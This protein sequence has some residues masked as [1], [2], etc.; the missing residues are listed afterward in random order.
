MLDQIITIFS[1]G[2]FLSSL[3]N[4]LDVMASIFNRYM[5]GANNLRVVSII[6][7]LLAFV[8]F[9]FLIIIL[10]VKS[11]ISFLKSDQSNADRKGASIFGDDENSPER[12]KEI[13]LEKE[14]E[15]ELE[16]ELEQAQT[17]KMFNEKKEQAEQQRNMLDEQQKG[18][19]EEKVYKES[20]DR[21]EQETLNKEREKEKAKS[22]T[23]DLDWKKGKISEAETNKIQ[24]DLN[25]MQ[26]QQSRKS[27]EEL[28]GLIIDMSGRGVDDL[29]IA[30]T[31]MF[32]NQGQ[33]TEDDIMQVI[34]AVKDFIALCIN[35]KF[36]NLQSETPIPKEDVALFHLAKGDPSV[37]LA[38]MEVLMD[39]GIDKSSQMT[40]GSKRDAI[41]REI[42]NH[43]C[44]FGSLASLSDV[45]LATGA[46][47]LSIELSP[48]NVNAWSRVADMYA[49]AESNNKAIWAYQNV[50][51]LADEE[52]YARQ[53]ANA[54]KALSQFYY[55]QGNSLQAAKLYNSSKQYY[56]SI[57]IN[58]RLDKKEV[59]IIEIIESR[60]SE[61]METTIAK[62]LQNRDMKQYSYG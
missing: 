59:E 45:H 31:I 55:S 24:V 61:D 19:K 28:L 5:S 30:Q 42:S 21:E 51:S 3:S 9:L 39:N 34:E 41:F 25:S 15:R 11:I 56:D 27:L 44:T 58:R 2:D 50:L 1:S 43:A 52:I 35:G 49:L 13:E 54:N 17:E 37:A 16:R 40:L 10:Y 6:L 57:G 62:I 7:M 8:L 20:K 29:K 53:V 26:Y 23:I 47:E 38:M 36:E 33:S 4:N 46:F 18:E 22:A 12:Q 14:L 60:N 48:Q 32:R